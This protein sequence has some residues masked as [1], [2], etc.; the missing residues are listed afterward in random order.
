MDIYKHNEIRPPQLLLLFVCHVQCKLCRPREG[1]EKQM[2]DAGWYKWWG[3]TAAGT[4]GVRGVGGGGVRIRPG[5]SMHL[6]WS[7]LCAWV[8]SDELHVFHLVDIPFPLPFP[9]QRC[10][11]GSS[12]SSLSLR[13]LV[14][15]SSG[16]GQISTAPLRFN[17][18]WRKPCKLSI[19]GQFNIHKSVPLLYGLYVCKSCLNLALIFLLMELQQIK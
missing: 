2:L 16:S 15:G 3:P 19:P 14:T 11:L 13:H 5:T 18:F 7:K 6:V 4:D 1:L 12:L 9:F 17:T 10:P 8:F